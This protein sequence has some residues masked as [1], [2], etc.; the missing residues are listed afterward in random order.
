[1]RLQKL[2]KI[3]GIKAC[4]LISGVMIFSSSF[5]QQ[6]SR[7]SVYVSIHDDQKKNH[8]PNA[9]F[10][11]ELTF[12]NDSTYK[13]SFNKMNFVLKSYVIRGK[14]VRDK[15]N[16]ILY[17]FIINRKGYLNS[18]KPIRKKIKLRLMANH[19][20]TYLRNKGVFKL[21]HPIIGKE[22]D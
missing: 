9:N 14:Y 17:D 1:M 11:E 15:T 2:I 13:Y 3:N 5:C 6:L 8:T 22:E 12:L 18:E 20:L 21:K 16:V 4:L 7:D 10:F 19:Q